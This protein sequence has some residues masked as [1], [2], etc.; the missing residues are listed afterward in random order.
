MRKLNSQKHAR[1]KAKLKKIAGFTLVELVV[2]IAIL[3]ILAAIA[4]PTYNGYINKT[5]DNSVELKFTSAKEALASVLSSHGYGYDGFRVDPQ[6]VVYYLEGTTPHSVTD[7]TL[8]KEFIQLYANADVRVTASILPRLPS[9]F[10]IPVYADGTSSEYDISG[11]LTLPRMAELMAK[12][13][14]YKNG[15]GTGMDGKAEGMVV[16]TGGYAASV[17]S[18]QKSAFNKSTFGTNMTMGTLMNEV[19]NVTAAVGS[20]F[21]GR[22]EQVVSMLGQDY[23]DYLNSI[24]VDASTL[25][26]DEVGNSLVLY[27]AHNSTDL[28]GAALIAAASGGEGINFD[29]SDMVGL[30]SSL[31]AMYGMVT[32][33]A[34]SD[35][36]KTSYL[37]DDQ[38]N[39]TTTTVKQAYDQMSTSI[40]G[41]QGG[42]AA[43]FGM[44]GSMEAI[45]NS[46]RMGEY[47]E[48]QA[49][50]DMDGYIASMQAIDDNISSGNLDANN[51][52]S[53][54][55][56]NQDLVQMLN[57]L[58]G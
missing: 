27:V 30:T 7:E 38:G 36:G 29:P 40:N 33:Y 54:G 4:V 26:S 44:L 13:V 34:N 23:T 52:I 31:A 17:T 24:G 39:P 55:V 48:K 35:I 42:A 43:M 56:T 32:A 8:K 25:T 46:S 53:S 47:M 2:V 49:Q 6:G 9:L 37:L 19:N 15:I 3:G 10:V 18:E 1:F 22:P 28:D 5:N 41:G 50:K 11:A 12:S 21:G 58:F 57:N 51:V 14:S 45:Q 16:G 20:I